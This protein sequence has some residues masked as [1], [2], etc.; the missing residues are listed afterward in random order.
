MSE[1]KTIMDFEN[2]YYE[3]ARD[4]GTCND[5]MAKHIAK[6]Q[7]KRETIR[8]EHITFSIAALDREFEQ[9]DEYREQKTYQ[10]WVEGL[11]KMMAG[12]RVKI[13]SLRSEAKGQY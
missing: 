12:V 8:K 2:L 3:I 11:A 13:E 9:T 5:W 1:A 10:Y 7:G 4:I 6:I